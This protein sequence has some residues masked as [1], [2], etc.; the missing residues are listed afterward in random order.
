MNQKS[1]RP[2]GEKVAITLSII[3]VA[4]MVIAGIVCAIIIVLGTVHNVSFGLNAWAGTTQYRFSGSHTYSAASE[5]EVSDITSIDLDWVA[6]DVYIQTG[7]VS[8]I[9]VREYGENGEN[10]VFD[11]SDVMRYKTSGTKLY[12]RFRSPGRYQNLRKKLYIT[13]PDDLSQTIDLNVNTVSANISI[14]GQD[15]L[16]S[17]NVDIETVSGDVTLSLDCKDLDINS[18]SGEI[19]LSGSVKDADIETVSSNIG[20]SLS[21][22]PSE[23][24][25]NTVSGN[26]D[27]NLPDE[28][29]DI[30]IETVSGRISV[31]GTT[32]KKEL[33]TENSAGIGELD[34]DT[35]S[36]NITVTTKN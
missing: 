9:T 36:G 21:S 14:D 6:G 20:V 17:D 31:N 23:L 35:V 16:Y 11:S 22:N 13:L 34:A 8:E 7:D 19:N 32:A 24:S 10:A 15:L 1:Q 26:I 12:I 28:L 27:V 3:A 30:D 25:F 5:F 33:D 2:A 18:V 29:E 4:V